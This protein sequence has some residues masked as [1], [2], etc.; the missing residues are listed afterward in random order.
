M[1]IYVKV[2]PGQQRKAAEAFGARLARAR[3][4]QAGGSTGHTPSPDQPQRF[5]GQPA[6]VQAATPSA[7]TVVPD[8]PAADVKK[9]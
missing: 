2:M 1:D 3:A 9:T 7:R 8:Q 5:S 4:V 6:G